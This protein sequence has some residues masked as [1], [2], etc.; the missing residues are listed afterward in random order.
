[1]D[2]YDNKRAPMAFQVWNPSYLGVSNKGWK[3]HSGDQYLI[4]FASSGIMPGDEEPTV[5]PKNDDWLISPEIVGGSVLSFWSKEATNQYGAEEF[6]ILTSST[7]D[8]IE[9]FT[10]LESDEVSSLEWSEFT[11]QLPKDAKY[12]AIRY[13]SSNKF[14]LLLDDISYLPVEG[15]GTIEIQG[16]NVYRD[17]EKITPQPIGEVSYLDA[18]PSVEEHTYTVSVV[19]DRGESLPSNVITISVQPSSIE[20]I[21]QYPFINTEYRTILIKGAEGYN[22]TIYTM[23]GK[24]ITQ[25]K[26]TDEENISVEPGVYLIN[27]NGKITKVIVK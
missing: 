13:I 19:Y 20:A 1:M 22:L 26:A 27:L 5:D 3:S 23:D 6:E 14:G 7:N 4:S 9:S 16:Y 11:Y 24:L 2:E 12:F 15:S 10:L 8:N 21:M 17:G 25:S 18:K